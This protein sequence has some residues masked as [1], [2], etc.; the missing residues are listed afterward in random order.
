MDEACSKIVLAFVLTP[1]ELTLMDEAC[2]NA[3]LAF[4]LMLTTCLLT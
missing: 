4:L 2:N 3:V 1:S